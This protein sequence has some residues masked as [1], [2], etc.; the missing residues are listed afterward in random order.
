MYVRSHRIEDVEVTWKGVK[1]NDVVLSG[2]AVIFLAKDIGDKLKET[3]MTDK[4]LGWYFLGNPL[5]DD[6][7]LMPDGVAVTVEGDGASFEKGL[8]G[9]EQLIHA[10]RHAGV[11]SNILCRTE[12]SGNIVRY[13]YMFTSSTRT[14]LWR[15]N[16]DDVLMA[17]ARKCA[18][19]V[20]HLWEMPGIV[21]R[22]L[23]TG[24]E[25]LREEAAEAT[26]ALEN[27]A[28]NSSV[29]HNAWFSTWDI[30]G[31]D[32]SPWYGKDDVLPSGYKKDLEDPLNRRV[33]A[34]I[35]FFAANNAAKAISGED[36]PYDV[37]MAERDRLN[38]IL[39]DMVEKAHADQQQKETL[40]V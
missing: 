21:R 37:A 13:R 26:N 39:T 5:L 38:R 3:E 33:P 10:S 35:A 11:N 18:L 14:V 15:L 12:H 6:G 25:T 16:V 22:Y 17:F 30:L 34:H 2:N 8:H 36:T 31:W 1:V 28:E 40:T 29:S 27:S 23:E 32:Y 7:P 19:E 20:S 24:D 4:V 9:C